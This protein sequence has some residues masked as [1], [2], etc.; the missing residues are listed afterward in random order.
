MATFNRLCFG[1]SLLLLLSF[2]G[3]KK[4]LVEERNKAFLL[5]FMQEVLVKGNI[6]NKTI[7]HYLHPD[8]K[9]FVDSKSSNYDGFIAHMKN[10]HSRGLKDLKIRYEHIIAKDNNV[11]TVHY[12]SA[13]LPSGATLKLKVIALFSFKDGKII[14]CDELTHLLEGDEGY[15]N[16]GSH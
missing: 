1:A 2:L 10:L 3:C 9:Q 12:P 5:D 4:T 15:R 6:D 8:F 7:S 13:I 14:L 11:I 16:I